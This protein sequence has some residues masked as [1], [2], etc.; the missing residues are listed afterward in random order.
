MCD[1]VDIQE[2]VNVFQHNE[3]EQFALL[4]CSALYPL[5]IGDSN[6]GVIKTLCQD[7]T[8]WLVFRSYDWK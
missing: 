2:A 6:V 1:W 3:N 5:E 7:I 4:Q 8:A